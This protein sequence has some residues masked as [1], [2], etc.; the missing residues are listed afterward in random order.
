MYHGNALKDLKFSSYNNP[1]VLQIDDKLLYDINR[2]LSVKKKEMIKNELD[3][4]ELPV[5]LRKL[6]VIKE[7][8][9]ESSYLTIGYLLNELGVKGK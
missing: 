7:S 3:N 1:S 8:N 6:P 9:L 5:A 2:K 4:S